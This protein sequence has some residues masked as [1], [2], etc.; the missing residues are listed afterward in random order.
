MTGSTAERRS[1]APRGHRVSAPTNEVIELSD[2]EPVVHGRVRG[3]DEIIDLTGDDGDEPVRKR[4][5]RAQVQ[6]PTFVGPNGEEG[7]D[8][9]QLDD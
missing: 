2:D 9:T 4:R 3:A 6:V 7:L 5:K 1:D 8:L